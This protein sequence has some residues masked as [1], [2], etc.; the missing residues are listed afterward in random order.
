[1]VPG[2]CIGLQL[3]TDNVQLIKDSL[4]S[5]TLASMSNPVYPYFL[6]HKQIILENLELCQDPKDI[7]AIHNF[8]LS[9]KRIKVVMALFETLKKG[10]F[11]AKEH[12]REIKKLY[13]CSGKLRDLQVTSLLMTDMQF[14]GLKPIIEAFEARIVKKRIKFEKALMAFDIKWLDQLDKELFNLLKQQSDKKLI[15]SGYLMLNALE[16]DIQDIFRSTTD[17]KRLHEIRTKIKDIIYLSNIFDEQL[18][19]QDHINISGE[20]LR[21]LGELAG[22]WHD[23]LNLEVEI[24]KFIEKQASHAEANSIRDF[25]AELLVKKQGLQQEYSCILIHEMKV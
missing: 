13:R 8:R 21:E 9:V 7:E 22:N 5:V 19:V 14:D 12:L 11:I 1:M 4:K 17:E 20:R 16:G 6:K 10:D 23:C 25:L 18:A 15:A 2:R 24:K 3:A